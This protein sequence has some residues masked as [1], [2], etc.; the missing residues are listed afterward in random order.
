MIL[1]NVFHTDA[2][3]HEDVP[4]TA[5]GMPYIVIHTKLDKFS[6]RKVSWHWHASLEFVYVEDGTVELRIP[7]QT[8]LLPKGTAVFIN[9]GVLHEYAAAAD[10]PCSI[11]ATLFNSQFLS[12]VHGSI[13]EEKYFQPICH[14]GI[15][16][17][18]V[19]RPDHLEGI[20]MIQAL[21]AS[22]KQAETEPEGYEFTV[23]SQLGSLWLGLW[24]ETR[25]IRQNSPSR[26]AADTERL[27][28]MMEFIESHYSENISAAD[29]ASAAGISSRES[30]RC[31]RR[32]IGVSPASYLSEYRV[33]MAA[34]M[35]TETDRSV[36]EISELCGFS[37]PGYFG[38][39]FRDT[40]RLTPKAYQK[41]LRM[42]EK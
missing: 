6:E 27:K 37:S 39:V 28:Q 8:Q 35:L 5:P 16:Q 19:I 12:G 18:W 11:Y 36:I 20:E 40:F 21:L 34:M 14:K 10:G 42:S 31:F 30:A 24:N 22:I 32:C 7:K 1:E 17:I 38:K 23:R 9:T 29:I 3:H 4:M 33:Q 25:E 41:K 26:N 13:F 2:R 15:P